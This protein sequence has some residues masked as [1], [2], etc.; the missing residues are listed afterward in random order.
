MIAKVSKK[1]WQ[2]WLPSQLEITLSDRSWGYYLLDKESDPAIFTQPDQGEQAVEA[3]TTDPWY[4][5]DSDS[6]VVIV[7]PKI[8]PVAR[9]REKAAH[10]KMPK[11]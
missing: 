2:F 5:P 4:D 8:M 11:M 10:G 9:A 1:W 6:N 7:E 3:G